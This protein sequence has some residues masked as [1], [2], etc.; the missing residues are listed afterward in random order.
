M[1]II[2]AKSELDHSDPLFIFIATISKIS[3]ITYS[4]ESK[5]PRQCL[6]HQEF[7]NGLFASEQLS[8][9]CHA[10]FFHGPEQYE[11]VSVVDLLIQ[12]LKSAYLSRP[13]P[14]NTDH[15]VEKLSV[16]LLTRI[17]CKQKVGEIVMTSPCPI[18]PG[19]KGGTVPS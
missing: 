8:I 16:A 3:E 4:R 13:I 19:F 18:N 12:K 11:F 9:Y 14:K 6:L 5:H 2:I 17:Q 1:H 10:M 15:K 7:Y